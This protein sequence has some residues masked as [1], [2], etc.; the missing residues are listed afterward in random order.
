MNK[1]T[2]FLVAAIAATLVFI[3]HMT[4]S[5]PKEFFGLTVSIWF[6]RIAWLIA[7]ISFFLNYNKLKNEKN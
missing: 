6:Y 4:E 5:E 3:G 2:L 7:A 1:K